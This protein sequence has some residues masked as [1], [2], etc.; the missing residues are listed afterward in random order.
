MKLAK[1]GNS[2]ALRIPA[3]VVEKLG[4]KADEEADVRVTGENSFEVVRNLRR[5]QAI[6]KMRAMRFVL[7]EG[8]KFDRDEI[9]DK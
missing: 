9:Y 7:P 2:L 5:Q 3:D 8:Y 1:W 4:L 6:E